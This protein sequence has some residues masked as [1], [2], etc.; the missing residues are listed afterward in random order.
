MLESRVRSLALLSLLLSS[1]L[2][3]P[4]AT[5]ACLDAD[6]DGLCDCSSGSQGQVLVEFGAPAR[7][8]ANLSDPGIGAAW[9]QPSFSDSSWPDGW[10]GVGYENGT[11]A[12]NLILTVVPSGAFSVYTR[13]TFT[14]GD[15]SRITA[16][17]MGADHDDGFVAYVNGVEVLRSPEMPAGVPAWNTS[18]ASHESSNG[19]LPDYSPLH[20]VTATGLPALHGGAN[21]L[22]VGVWS[23]DAPTDVDLVL[24]PTLILE[25]GGCDN[26]PWVANPA[27][28]DQD[29]DGVG[30]ACDNCPSVPNPG[31]EDQDADAIGDACD[32]CPTDAS[33]TCACPDSDGDE[34]CDPDDDCPYVPDPAQTDTDFDG[35]GDA[36]DPCP[37]D[38]LDQCCSD[39]DGDGVCS[40][41][42]NCPWVHNPS[43]ADT[44][45]DGLGDPCDCCPFDP[46]P[47]LCDL[48]VDPLLCPSDDH[49]GDAVP[50]GVDNCPLDAN[51]AQF[52]TDGDGEG[53]ACDPCPLDATN[54]CGPCAAEV[55]NDGI[56]NDCNPAT[57]DVFDLDADG[58]DCVADCDDSDPTVHPGAIEVC[59]DGI[60]NDCD[61]EAD[62]GA[63]FDGDGI[64]NACDNCVLEPNPAQSDADGDGE[65]DACDLDDGMI[66]VRFHEPATVSWQ[67]ESGFEAWNCYRGDLDVLTS[68]GP[69][70][71]E[72]GS[73][74][75]AGRECGLEDPFAPDG[76]VVDPGRVAFYLITGMADGGE[77]GLGHGRA[78]GNP[79]P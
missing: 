59:G 7:Y 52:D 35:L 32:P 70:T 20:D 57:P 45:A 78:N 43:Q 27:Q 47:L 54:T 50:N 42:D 16:V 6:A 21:L 12:E 23:H 63:D 41:D 13:A 2:A 53:D 1:L 34:V 71:Q 46:Y 3:A 28:G 76:A 49:D 33:G 31:Q 61:G 37:L 56:D 4:V 9:T 79:C 48:D 24:V 51:P 39:L 11:G 69:C 22:A 72:P 5:L 75:L 66:Y 55:C 60:D 38:P 44:D 64:G 18:A 67:E 15:P 36:C 17:R 77:S 19:T 74:P 8:L 73:N 58:F 68:G 30:D 10:Y 25:F 62:G 14:V 29:A 26:C 65:G 40:P